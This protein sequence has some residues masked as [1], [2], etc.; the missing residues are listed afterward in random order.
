MKS[1]TVNSYD[2]L[3]VVTIFAVVLLHTAAPV[4]H[5][6]HTISTFD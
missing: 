6:L 1:S 5:E 3:R 2:Y 4:L